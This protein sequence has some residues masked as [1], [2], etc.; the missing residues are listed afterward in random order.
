MKSNSTEETPAFRQV[1]MVSG[2]EKKK[3]SPTQEVL[4][5]RKRIEMAVKCLPTN[6]EE[7]LKRYREA[8]EVT[9]NTFILIL[10]SKWAA[11]T[12]LALSLNET[13]EYEESAYFLRGSFTKLDLVKPHSAL[14]EATESFAQQVVARG[15]TEVERVRT[16]AL[17]A[18]DTD[19]ELLASL[20][21]SLEAIL[22]S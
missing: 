4:D 14:F 5:L 19:L 6:E 20:M 12:E 8:K 9:V 16:R 15:E 11:T 18:L 13:V 2:E 21:P 3:D 22:G 17:E 7:L 1:P 10:G